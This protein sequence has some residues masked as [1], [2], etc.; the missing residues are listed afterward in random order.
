MVQQDN[1]S[2]P[3]GGSSDENIPWVG[4]G[5]HKPRLEYL[6]AENSDY[7]LSNLKIDKKEKC[8]WK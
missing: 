6:V 2:I 4:I 3:K 1:F 7:L 5:M 8:H